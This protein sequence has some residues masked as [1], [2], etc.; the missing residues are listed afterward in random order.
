MQSDDEY[1][2]RMTDKY[3]DQLK[4]DKLIIE[5][6]PDLMSLQFM[7]SLNPCQLKLIFCKNIIPTLSRSTIKELDITYCKVQSLEQYQLE[8]L[9]FLK[10]QCYKIDGVECTQILWNIV[11]FPKLKQLSLFGFIDVDVTPLSQKA[12]SITKLS[13]NYCE[14]KNVEKLKTLVNMKEL[15]I[16]YNQYVDISALREMSQLLALDLSFCSLES[17]ETLR[18]LV[19]LRDL[20][21]RCNQV[22][23]TPLQYLSELVRIDLNSCGIC[24]ISVLQY[25]PNLEEV[26]IANNSIVYIQPL[27]ELNSIVELD[28]RFN[29]YQTVSFSDSLS[30]A[31]QIYSIQLY[32]YKYSPISIIF[33]SPS[34]MACS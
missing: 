8:N 10:L 12:L 4:D 1:D 25:L 18:S 29:P 32:V 28:A 24:Y 6:D 5:N 14:L 3:L 30:S 20:K 11:Q 33:H 27:Q 31:P 34:V 19:N 2:Q 23:I 22:D 13:L 7:R 26:D 16:A 9:E 21:L 15:N 17:I